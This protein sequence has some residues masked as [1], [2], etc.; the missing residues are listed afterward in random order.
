MILNHPNRNFLLDAID[1]AERS[2]LRN[3]SL[4]NM[5]LYATYHDKNKEW[6][7]YD[8][9]EPKKAKLFIRKKWTLINYVN[10]NS[11]IKMA[12]DKIIL[13]DREKFRDNKGNTIEVEV[14]GDRD[15]EKCYFKAKDIAEGF[16]IKNLNNTITKNR[17]D[18]K[19]EKNIHYVNFNCTSGENLSPREIKTLFLTYEGIL[20]VLYSSHSDKAKSFRGW[21]TQTLFI[22]QMGSKSQKQELASSILRT[23]PDVIKS[24]FNKSADSFPCVYL[25]KLGIVKDFKK[26]IKTK[27][28]DNWVLFKFGR[29][30]DL[31]RRTIEHE[32]TYN[33]FN[34]ELHKFTYID[35]IYCSAAEKELKDYFKC[36]SMN[37][38]YEKHVEIVACDPN[39]IDQIK[40][41]F[42]GIKNNY[43][44]KALS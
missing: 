21:A 15:P 4:K 39:S 42:E 11:D 44:G 10:F 24:T 9:N 31:K 5:Y 26:N 23:T 29:T 13:K 22:A 43:S 12:P 28:P 33:L 17:N 7:S 14:R 20:K 34:L 19:Y 36:A 16:G 8:E 38:T 37:V 32:T 40:N 30:D 2:L 41:L 35:P 27:A 18:I 1:Q 25:F 3:Q 6:T